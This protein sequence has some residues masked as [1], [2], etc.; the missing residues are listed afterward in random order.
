MVLLD[1]HAVIWA[2]TDDSRLGQAART[3]ITAAT[4]ES[5]AIADITLLEVSMLA[6]KGRITCES[7]LAST[8]ET[9]AAKVTVLP[10]DAVIAAEAMALAL[11]QGDPFDR[12]IVAT[13]RRYNLPLLTR[14]QAI[15]ESGL[16]EVVW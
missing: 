15:T 6:A 9:I 4:A 5:L 13:A 8:L 10:I 2:I 12:V 14:D 7:S 3:R 16:V 1:T 11:P